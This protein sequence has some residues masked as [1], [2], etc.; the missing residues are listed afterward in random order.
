MSEQKY[1]VLASAAKVGCAKVIVSLLKGSFV[2]MP[3]VLPCFFA[4]YRPH[5]FCAPFSSGQRVKNIMS[6]FLLTQARPSFTSVDTDGGN[7]TG[8]DHLPFLSSFDSHI[9]ALLAPVIIS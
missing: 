1:S 3:Q 4:I 7:N 8:V 2:A 9:S 6:P 5:L